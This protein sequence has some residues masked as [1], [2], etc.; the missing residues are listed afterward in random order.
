MKLPQA[1]RSARPQKS[2]LLKISNFPLKIPRSAE[3]PV[4]NYI[5]FSRISSPLYLQGVVLATT[6]KYLKHILVL[7]FPKTTTKMFVVIFYM[8][9]KNV[10]EEEE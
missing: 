6:K 10:K 2:T 8:H 5:D 4:S 9:E 3:P 1:W 7:T